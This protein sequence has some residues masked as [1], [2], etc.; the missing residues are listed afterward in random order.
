MKKKNRKGKFST[1]ARF[2]RATSKVQSSVFLATL[3]AC[4]GRSVFAPVHTIL[5]FIGGRSY[6]YVCAGARVRANIYPSPPFSSSYSSSLRIYSLTVDFRRRR[7]RR[8]ASRAH[9]NR[10]RPGANDRD[11][12]KYISIGFATRKKTALCF[13]PSTSPPIG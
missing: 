6:I 1:C 12:Y 2:S 8:S 3:F 7:R 9:V 10:R 4:L 13:G 11:V 5:L